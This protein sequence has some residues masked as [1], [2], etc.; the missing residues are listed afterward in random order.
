[1]L[2]NGKSI[3]VELDEQIIFE[4]LDEDENAIWSLLL[5]TGYLRVEE[6]ERRGR[7]LEI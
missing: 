6:L 4:Q 5:A 7:L 2:L 1:M 3:E